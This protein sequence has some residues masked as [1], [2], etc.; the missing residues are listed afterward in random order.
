MRTKRTP[1]R[2]KEVIPMR[3][4]PP[5]IRRLKSELEGRYFYPAIKGDEDSLT[6]AD[7]MLTSITIERGDRFGEWSVSGEIQGNNIAF[8]ASSSKN[9][10]RK[11]DERLKRAGLRN[12]FLGIG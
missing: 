8:S 12:Q 4:L 1:T 5:D 2:E 9:L 6:I 10:L 11:I 7:G 3:E